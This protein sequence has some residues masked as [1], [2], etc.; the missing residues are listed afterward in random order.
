MKIIEGRVICKRNLGGI[1]FLHVLFNNLKLNLVCR[2]DLLGP[3]Y[4]LYIKKI[5]LGSYCKFRVS[6]L[7]EEIIVVELVSITVPISEKIWSES[8][9]D[10]IRAFAYYLSLF[11]QY[12]QQHGYVEVRLPSIHY[13]L[14]KGESF[15][16]NF[17]SHPARLTTSNALYLNVYAV[18]LGKVFSLQKCFRAE[19]SKTNRHLAEFDL[20][21]VAI[22]ETGMEACIK[23]LEC[24]VKFVVQGLADS[25]FCRMQ[26]IDVNGLLSSGF[27]IVQYKEIADQYGL[28]SS[29]LG[30]YEREIATGKPVF[31]VNYPK[32]IASWTAKA[33]DDRYSK[34][35]NL[36]VPGIGEVAEGN[37]KQ[38]DLN[39]LKTLIDKAQAHTQLGWYL[40]MMP[41]SDYM[42]SGFGLGVERLFMWIMGIK[43]IR[44]IK[45]FYRDTSFSELKPSDC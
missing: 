40:D 20:L 7:G 39:Y 45:P 14:N 19:K 28:D 23:E 4:Y 41:Y 3:D 32:K 15:L 2:R 22:L 31:V 24:L 34:S 11:R 33:I 43:N 13:G 44:K 35:F 5:K 29:G 17:F 18:Q 30:K 26:K 37:E 36:V 6:D 10:I 42:L 25:E 21:E 8:R 38:T 9:L 12:F 1:L 16:L 27:Q